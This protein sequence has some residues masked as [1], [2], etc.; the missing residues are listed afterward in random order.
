MIGIVDPPR[1]E[2][3]VAIQQAHAAG[4]CV[5]MITGDHPVTAL[6]IGKAMGIPPLNT[7]EPAD[8][9]RGGGES[10]VTGTQLDEYIVS[11]M[12][13]FDEVVVSNNIFART[14]PEHK[15]RIV[16]SLQR[17]GFVCSM[18]GD[19]VNDAPALKAANIGANCY[20]AF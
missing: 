18:T 20:F 9:E 8:L 17:Q 1:P 14:T 13:T 4:I 3:T 2:A 6:A 11:S 12:E 10:A 5:K 7:T 16:Q 15:L 19:G